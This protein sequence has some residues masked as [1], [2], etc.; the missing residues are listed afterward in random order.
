VLSKYENYAETSINYVDE[1]TYFV[2]S[3]LYAFV[4]WLNSSALGTFFI[5]TRPI[6]LNCASFVHHHS[7]KMIF[8]IKARDVS[9]LRQF[10]SALYQNS[11][12]THL[13]SLFLEK[14][15]RNVLCVFT[16]SVSWYILHSIKKSLTYDV[17][18]R[19]NFNIPCSSNDGRHNCHCILIEFIFIE[20]NPSLK[21]LSVK[22]DV[23]LSNQKLYEVL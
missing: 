1:M 3:E 9:P 18:Q 2:I 15:I 16:Y 22:W 12:N 23:K 19:M 17:H 6:N 5:I 4:G 21:G 14:L 20:G 11:I 10:N 7:L 8:N 13:L